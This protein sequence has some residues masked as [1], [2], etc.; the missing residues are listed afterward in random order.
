MDFLDDNSDIHVRDLMN[1]LWNLID[2]QAIIE[3]VLSPSSKK[4][5]EVQI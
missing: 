5:L 3:H 4:T 2:F 1:K